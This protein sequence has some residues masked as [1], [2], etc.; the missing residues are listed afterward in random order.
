VI[1]LVALT[2]GLIWWI[3]AWAFDIKA[4]DAFMLTVLMV[5]LAAAYTIAK[6]FLNQLLGRESASMEEKGGAF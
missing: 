1:I 5:V 6:P 4:F 2:V 3:V